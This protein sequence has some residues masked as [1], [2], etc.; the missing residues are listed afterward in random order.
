MRGRMAMLW[1]NK[2][3]WKCDY[4]PGAIL[5]AHW[6]STNEIPANHG[7]DEAHGERDS[8][9]VYSRA[10]IDG[11]ATTQ[12]SSDARVYRGDAR[13]LGQAGCYS[14]MHD[15]ERTATTRPISSLR[16]ASSTEAAPKSYSDDP[17][18]AVR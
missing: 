15:Y 4:L 13:R 6:R 7:S 17:E 18:A 8:N 14:Q 1:K 3:A 12:R 9:Y 16:F 2:A 10:G 5:K 11:C